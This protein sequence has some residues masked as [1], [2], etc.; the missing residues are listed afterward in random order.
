MRKHIVWLAGVAALLLLAWPVPGLVGLAGSEPVIF[1]NH[2][3]G[4][5]LFGLVYL[6]IVGAV[7]AANV[8]LWLAIWRGRAE[9]W[10]DQLRGLAGRPWLLGLVA[11]ALVSIGPVVWALALGRT[12]LAEMPGLAMGVRFGLA[13]LAVVCLALH[14]W[15]SSSPRHDDRG[16][17]VFLFLLVSSVYYPTA[18]GITG[19][20]DGSHYALLRAMVTERRFEIE[21]FIDYTLYTDYVERDGIQYSDRPPGTALASVPFYLLGGVLS[22]LAADMPS[23]VERDNPGLALVMI[24]PALSGAG[25]VVLLYSLLRSYELSTQAALTASLALAF[26]TTLWKYGSVLFSHGLAALCVMVGVVLALRIVRS[27][28]VRWP[29]ALLLGLVLGCSVLVEYSN[30]IFFTAVVVFVAAVLNKALFRPG[31]WRSL[32]MFSLGAILPIGFLMWYHTVNFGGPLVPSYRYSVEFPWAAQFSTT[33]DG[34]LGQGLRGMLWF[35]GDW[36]GMINQGIFLLMPVTLVALPGA[37][38]F[39]RRRW[40]EALLVGGLLLV[41]L[42]LFAKHRSFGTGTADSRYIVPFLALLFVPVGFALERFFAASDPTARAIL[43]FA[44]YGLVFISIFNAMVHIGTSVNYG[45]NF[46][47]LTWPAANPANWLHLLDSILVNLENLPL[48]WIVEGV[49]WLGWGAARALAGRSLP[50]TAV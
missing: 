20:N 30:T 38:F 25:V 47:Q 43:S 26:G 40:R 14:S 1:G 50:Q 15:R 18:S 29:M 8:W 34:Q 27:G 32:A 3:P 7:V 42:V 37:W 9:Q 31:W 17:A 2:G 19:S 4:W 41:Y 28:E 49:A 35:A 6:L 21:T 10:A 45:F 23:E 24:L 22:P 13:P 48:L 46:S 16:T 39:F 33:F 44:A 11:V 5:T 12:P 36:S